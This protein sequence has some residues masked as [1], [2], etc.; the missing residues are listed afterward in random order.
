MKK[1]FILLGA[2][3]ALLLLSP[4]ATGLYIKH[5]TEQ[6]MVD[7]RA[8]NP[9]VPLEIEEYDR[10][11]LTSNVRYSV[12]I[13]LPPESDDSDFDD[14]DLDALLAGEDESAAKIL[15]YKDSSE[16]TRAITFYTQQR[17]HHGPL[18]WAALKD[19]ALPFRVG[20][21][22]TA[23]EFEIPEQAK[24]AIPELNA[25]PNP[26]IY[27]HISLM[28]SMSLDCDVPAGELSI[29][30]EL[31]DTPVNVSWQ[32]LQCSGHSN[33]RSGAGENQVV[34]PRV[35]VKNE[36]AALFI[37]IGEITLNASTENMRRALPLQ[38]FDMLVDSI[39][40]TLFD[41]PMMLLNQLSIAGNI[42]LDDDAPSD[43]KEYLKGFIEYA[44]D[45]AVVSDFVVSDA[46]IR[47]GIDD[48]D[49]EASELAQVRFRELTAA[50]NAQ[51]AD[52]EPIDMAQLLLIDLEELLPTM[53]EHGRVTIETI[54]ATLPDGQLEANGEVSVTGF[55]KEIFQQL[56]SEEAPNP[57]EMLSLL[58]ADV[59]L[60]IDEPLSDYVLA[61]M[62]D[63]QLAQLPEDMPEEQ[64]EQIAVMVE[65]QMGGMLE[66]I[67]EQGMVVRTAEGSKVRLTTKATLRAGELQVNGQPMELPF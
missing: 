42:E 17:L 12:N 44:V 41:E 18:P 38:D 11:W 19:E 8:A 46:K 60:T 36:E 57:M 34:L 28:G 2:V 62:V 67:V 9:S 25:V 39:T 29:S 51:P 53:L 40:V 15:S 21:G 32:A 5:A 47:I 20:L 35:Q 56:A 63:K 37:D 50:V 58:N 6:M 26:K 59:A 49:R 24:A 7:F 1:L 22:V 43:D 23:Y 33:L 55:T 4:L 3:V 61:Y 66:G 31:A 65:E 10:G 27:S 16:A 45:K 30:S 52:Q 48:F 14:F 64:L 13:P 54:E